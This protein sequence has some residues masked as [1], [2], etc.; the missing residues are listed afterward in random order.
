V[1]EKIRKLAEQAFNKIN[2]GNINDIKIPNEFIKEFGELI[3]REC[4]NL[5]ENEGR[6]LKY[7][8]L[9]AKLRNTYGK[10]N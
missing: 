3:V 2:D 8:K 6:F 10:S 7:D 4:A 9:A 5:V 1:N